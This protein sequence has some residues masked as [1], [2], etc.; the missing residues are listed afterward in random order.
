MNALANTAAASPE[1]SLRPV[2]I[3]VVTLKLI[4]AAFL[5]TSV[6]LSG[7][8]AGSYDLASR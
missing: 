1:K 8:I 2:V 4:V 5:L 6:Q 3:T 7:P